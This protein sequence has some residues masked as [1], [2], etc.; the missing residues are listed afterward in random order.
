MRSQVVL[1]GVVAL[2][3]IGCSSQEASDETSASGSAAAVAPT[4]APA[5][6]EPEGCKSND[7]C[8]ENEYCATPPGEC[9]GGGECAVKP[10]IC[11]EIWDPVCGCNDKTYSNA[12]SAAAAGQSVAYKG[13]CRKPDG[14]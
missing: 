10:E 14:A 5:A 11:T 1:I 6:G 4:V 13:E 7:D 8:A 9:D 2:A 12:C 3:L